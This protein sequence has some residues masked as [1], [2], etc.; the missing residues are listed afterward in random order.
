MDEDG[1]EAVKPFLKQIPIDYTLGLGSGTIGELPITVIIGRDGKV[2][3]RLE[4]L[5]TPEEIRAA[6][7]K[8]QNAG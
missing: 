2:A 5:K 4:G 7:A 8:A 6:I 1:A 3:Q